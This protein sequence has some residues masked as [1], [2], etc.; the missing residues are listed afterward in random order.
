[1]FAAIVAELGKVATTVA[2]LSWETPIEIDAAAVSA[3]LNVLPAETA[4][5]AV[6]GAVSAAVSDCDC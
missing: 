1:M 3:L 5:V 2:A 4:M 6:P